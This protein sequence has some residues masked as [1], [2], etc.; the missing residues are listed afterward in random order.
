[1]DISKQIFLFNSDSLCYQLVLRGGGGF[2]CLDSGEEIDFDEFF[3]VCTF[4]RFQFW[5]AIIGYCHTHSHQ[6]I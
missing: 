4:F 5:F 3:E 6:F 2:G 1:V